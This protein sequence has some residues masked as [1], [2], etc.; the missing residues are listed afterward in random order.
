MWDGLR[1]GGGTAARQPAL[2][3]E[4]GGVLQQE[5][6]GVGGRGGG[7]EGIQRGGLQVLQEECQLGRQ[8]GGR[9]GGGRERC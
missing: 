3:A 2:R 8:K 7:E 6:L 4:L 9:E 5:A 1:G